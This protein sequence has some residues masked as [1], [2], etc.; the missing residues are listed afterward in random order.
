MYL[1]KHGLCIESVLSDTKKFVLTKKR[2]KFG[3]MKTNQY[4]KFCAYAMTCLE[5]G[6]KAFLTP[7]S[8]HLMVLIGLFCLSGSNKLKSC[9]KMKQSFERLPIEMLTQ[10][11]S[12]AEI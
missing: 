9:F 8:L 2:E 3:S 4:S 5:T 1:C 10:L 6:L 12:T 7:Q 11:E